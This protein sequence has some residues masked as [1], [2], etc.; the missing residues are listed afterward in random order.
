M[1]AHEID[2]AMAG[3]LR[4]QSAVCLFLGIWYALGLSFIGLNFGFLIGVI[5]G[6]LSLIPFVGSITAFVLSISVAH[7][8]GLA[9]MAPAAR[10]HRRG[11]RRACFSTAM[12]CRRGW[13]AP[14]WDCIRCG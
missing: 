13:S 6:F 11:L 1:L 2:Q 14:R 7:G 9:G 3:F 8:A 4:G 5:A 12:C 10:S